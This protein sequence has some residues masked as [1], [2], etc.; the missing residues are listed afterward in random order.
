MISLAAATGLGDAIEAAGGDPGQILRS[1]GF[2]RDLLGDRHR[3]IPSAD[4]ARI[5]E[6]AARET[7]DEC[8]G[9]H[10]GER[11]HPKALG[12]LVYVVVNSPSFAVAFENVARFLRVHNEAAEWGSWRGPHAGTCDTR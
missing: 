7:G 2:E 12:P 1:L 10:F 6:S 8:F 5:L 3:F 11:F 4:F 9:L